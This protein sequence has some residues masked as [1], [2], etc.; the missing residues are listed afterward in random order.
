MKT[1]NAQ[2]KIVL[3]VITLLFM[4]A[5]ICAKLNLLGF[6]ASEFTNF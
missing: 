2:Q 4:A 5:I 6:T 3:V 1:L